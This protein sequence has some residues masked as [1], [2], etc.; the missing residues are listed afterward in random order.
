MNMKLFQVTNVTCCCFS[1]NEAIERG[2][3][4]SAEITKMI[5]VLDSA[6]MSLSDLHAKEF[7]E[8]ESVELKIEVQRKLIS[9]LL[10]HAAKTGG[11]AK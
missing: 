5:E 11:G 4:S 2:A 1:F 9:S 8:L 3:K 6:I 7:H 10:Q